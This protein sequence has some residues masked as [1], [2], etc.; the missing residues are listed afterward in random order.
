MYHRFGD[1]RYPSTNITMAQFERQLDYLAQNGYRI[2][3]LARIVEHLESDRAIP[4]RTVAL[5]V[6]DAY[7]SVYEK[8]YPLLRSRKVPVTVFV[9]TD[10]VDRASPEHMSWAQMRRMGASG[11]VH[12]ANHGASHDHLA[13]R[14]PGESHRQWE[15]RVSGD[16]LKAQARLDEELGRRRPTA[17]LFA[18]PYGEYS[19][20]LAGLVESLGFTAFGQHSGAIGSRSDRRALPRYPMAEAFADPVEFAVKAASLPLPVI[21]QTPRDPLTAA[22]PP[23][24][25]FTVAPGP[26]GLNELAC[27]AA[28]QGRMTLERHGPRTFSVQAHKPLSPGRSR[29][30]C[31]APHERENRFFWFSQ[32]WL[33]ETPAQTASPG[34]RMRIL[35]P[36][37]S[38]Q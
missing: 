13:L 17:R 16:V 22:N 2:W 37:S 12:F 38:D 36:R 5:T 8:A 35:Q 19:S 15:E 10:A 27:Y 4:N 20:A 32:P 29:Y 21:E 33:I 9:S 34:A 1:S 30:N 28:G 31:T 3:P 6:D 24:F 7:R 18:Y 26:V 14:R 11:L 25:R 23:R